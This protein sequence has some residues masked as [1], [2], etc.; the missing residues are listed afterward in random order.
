MRCVLGLDS[1]AGNSATLQGCVEKGGRWNV[2]AMRRPPEGLTTSG[3]VAEGGEMLSPGLAIRSLGTLGVMIRQDVATFLRAQPCG[4]GCCPAGRCRSR[5]PA[6]WFCW[7]CEAFLMR[8]AVAC[9]YY[10]EGGVT[11]HP[12]QQ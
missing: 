6:L 2:I 1:Q 3:I 7:P 12:D 4:C 5:H 11:A 9:D 8:Q 10:S